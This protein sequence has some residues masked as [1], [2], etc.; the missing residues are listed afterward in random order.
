MS[1][2]IKK[3]L[4]HCINADCVDCR[5]DNKCIECPNIEELGIGEIVCRARLLQEVLEY[6]SDLQHR[7]D[8]VEKALD[9]MANDWCLI[10]NPNKPSDVV[11]KYKEKVERELKGA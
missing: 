7:L 6:I 5:I 10:D 4:E 3:A 8:V 9:E 2:D 1:K 11:K